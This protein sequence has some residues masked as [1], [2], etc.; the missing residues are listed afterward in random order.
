MIVTVR[1]AALAVDP[2]QASSHRAVLRYRR[3]LARA[4]SWV[5]LSDG[6]GCRHCS[7]CTVLCSL[8]CQRPGL[9]LQHRVGVC[10]I[11]CSPA[12]KP[13]LPDAVIWVS[14]AGQLHT[15]LASVL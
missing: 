9:W 2:K 5:S 15:H 7:S 13:E 6:E 8:P 14:S 4:E 1:Q 12:R 10:V 11:P 3:M